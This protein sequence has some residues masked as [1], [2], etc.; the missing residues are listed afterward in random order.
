[1]DVTPERVA[2]VESSPIARSVFDCNVFLQAIA[3]SRGP[4]AV[5][6]ELARTGVIE[7]WSSDDIGIELRDVLYR[8]P[9]RSK[10]P[11]LTDEAAGAFLEELDLIA[12]RIGAVSPATIIVRDPKDQKYL[13]LAAT[14]GCQYIVTRDR[15]L[16]SLMDYDDFRSQYPHL[17]VVDPIQVIRCIAA[18]RDT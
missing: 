6:W 14:A 4:A 5:C 15:D 3:S 10:F 16:L 13:D 2:S 8:G 17:S 7:L 1:M 12:R 18:N 11:R 9:L